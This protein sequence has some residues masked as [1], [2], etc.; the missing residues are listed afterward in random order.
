MR[1]YCDYDTIHKVRYETRT[2][3]AIHL[4]EKHWFSMNISYAVTERVF[5]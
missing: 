5:E 1:C 2:P 4:D 3:E